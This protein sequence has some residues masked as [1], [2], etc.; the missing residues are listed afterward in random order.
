[1]CLAIPMRVIEIR[2]GRDTL[3]DSSVALV[4]SD[5]I[6]KEV[7]LDLVNRMPEVGDYLIIHAGYAINC[8]DPQEAEES[9]RLM[10]RMA[11]GSEVMPG[12]SA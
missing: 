1:M 10:R 9:L 7:R 12:G 2:D 3:F 8:L 4:D 11:E 5:G 6:T